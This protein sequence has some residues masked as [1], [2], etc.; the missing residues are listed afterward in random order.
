MVG[1]VADFTA[2][3]YII[4]TEII[5]HQRLDIKIQLRYSNYFGFFKYG[6]NHLLTS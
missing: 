5:V 4:K 6:I 2:D 3:Y 1:K